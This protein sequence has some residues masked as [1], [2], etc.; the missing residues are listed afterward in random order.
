MTLCPKCS[1][2]LTE[3]PDYMYCYRCSSQFKRRLFGGLKE[4]RNTLSRD[5]NK[6]MGRR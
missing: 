6:A 5:Q 1:V 2:E 4:V 3:Y